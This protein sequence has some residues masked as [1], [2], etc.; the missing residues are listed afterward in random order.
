MKYGNAI[1]IYLIETDKLMQQIVN[2]ET[3]LKPPY[4]PRDVLSGGRT[5]AIA[6]HYKG[7]GDYVDFTSLYP[8]VQKYGIFPPVIEK[9]SQ[10]I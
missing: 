9:Y 5:N 4:N 7:V 10:I 8:Y 3:E 2:Y 6:L 1:L